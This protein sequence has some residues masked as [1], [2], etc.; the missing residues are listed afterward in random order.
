MKIN[1]ISSTTFFMH[2]GPSAAFWCLFKS[3][4]ELFFAPKALLLYVS[5]SNIW[6]IY[7]WRYISEQAEITL[8]NEAIFGLLQLGIFFHL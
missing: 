7:N 4:L 6:S 1:Q 2:I 8:L 3:R 5:E